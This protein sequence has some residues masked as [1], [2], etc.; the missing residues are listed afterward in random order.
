MFRQLLKMS[1]HVQLDGT[2]TGSKV[3][4]SKMLK[5]GDHG[6]ARS[7][8]LERVDSLSRGAGAGPSCLQTEP[9]T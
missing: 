9:L 7:S 2:K 5:T 1:G 4:M 3:K 6:G 8:L